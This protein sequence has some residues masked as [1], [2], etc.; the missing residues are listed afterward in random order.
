M[1]SHDDF[2][3]DAAESLGAESVIFLPICKE[4]YPCNTSLLL[5]FLSAGWG[6]HLSVCDQGTPT[7]LSSHL[8]RLLLSVIQFVADLT[9]VIASTLR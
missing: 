6:R 4:A 1:A 8:I 7:P 3:E 2:L 5:S 9:D